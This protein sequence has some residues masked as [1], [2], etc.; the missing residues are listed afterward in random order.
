MEG[1]GG[2]RNGV[3]E[4]YASVILGGLGV[5]GN[6][7]QLPLSS[8]LMHTHYTPTQLFRKVIIIFPNMVSPISQYRLGRSLQSI[9]ES[10]DVCYF[11]SISVGYRIMAGLVK[12]F[13]KCPCYG[14]V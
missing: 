8:S 9:C 4:T 5:T 2:C 13:I 14:P 7:A 3:P 6:D 1:G 12:S 11:Y 10:C